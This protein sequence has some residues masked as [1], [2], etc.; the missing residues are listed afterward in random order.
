MAAAICVTWVW[1]LSLMAAPAPSLV[2]YGGMPAPGGGCFKAAYRRVFDSVQI[3]DRGEV[4]FRAAVMDGNQERHGI[5]CYSLADKELRLVARDDRFNAGPDWEA[6][7]VWWP[8]FDRR[9]NVLFTGGLRSTDS[10]RRRLFVIFQDD[11]HVQVPLLRS[12]D[13][14]ARRGSWVGHF[15]R[16]MTPEANSRGDTVLRSSLEYFEVLSDGSEEFRAEESGVYVRW[17]GNAQWKPVLHMFD[18]APGGG[19]VVGTFVDKGTPSLGD[20]QGV[21][22][23]D[24]GDVCYASRIGPAPEPDFIHDKRAVLYRPYGE[25]WQRI[26]TEGDELEYF[27][28]GIANHVVVSEIHVVGMNN[29]GHVACRVREAGPVAKD[30]LF[31]Y[32]NGQWNRVAGY[33][34]PA[35]VPSSRWDPSKPIVGEFTCYDSM[36][37]ALSNSR[38]PDGAPGRCFP[39]VVFQ[40]PVWPGQHYSPWFTTT[41]DIYAFGMG[42]KTLPV[43]PGP[44]RGGF[45]PGGEEVVDPGTPAP[46]PPGGTLDFQYARLGVN[47]DGFI[48]VHARTGGATRREIIVLTSLDQDGDGLLDVW[49]TEGLDVNG[50]GAIDLDLPALHANPRHKDLFLEIDYMADARHSDRPDPRAVQRVIDAFAQAPVENPDGTNGIT[51]H[52]DMTTADAIPP[53][54]FLRVPGQWA[55]LVTNWFGTA[56]ERAGAN[57]ADVLL[58]KR[59]VFRY[60]IFGHQYQFRAADGHWR[61]TTSSGLGELPGNDFLVTLGAFTPVADQVDLQAGTLMHE[62]GHTL[63]LR[64]GGD[65]DIN[66]KPNYLSV[67]SYSRQFS[68]MI[69]NRP[70]DY[71]RGLLPDLDERHLDERGGIGGSTNDLS[72]FFFDSNGDGYNDMLCLI[73][74]GAPVD[75]NQ[76]TNL[77]D[78]EVGADINSLV[79]DFDADGNPVWLDGWRGNEE[80]NRVILHDFND[81]THLHYNFRHSRNYGQGVNLT[82]SHAEMDWD[83]YQAL[84]RLAEE[85]YASAGGKLRIERA[86]SG[87]LRLTWPARAPACRLQSSASITGPW[88]NETGPFEQ[89][90]AHWQWTVLPAERARFYRLKVD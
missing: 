64:H 85:Y 31:V 23:S 55:E 24:Q 9:G 86:D 82:R 12:D 39:E 57:A 65:D 29:H 62:L 77:T 36:T 60:C 30:H 46:D 61:K 8:R 38:F 67:M 10:D 11:G 19:F 90:N 4:L 26:L 81:W 72:V 25:N 41:F 20:T 51:L 48:V 63:G 37:A 14:V 66:A 59:S 83:T 75:W 5:Y 78:T 70:L 88:V 22:I 74:G 34:D 21:W 2:A 56:A 76:N 43:L 54:P 44:I 33:G 80:T 7:E 87:L 47:A 27:H 52:V 84:Q 40:T 17:A 16:F 42:R 50:D 3:S 68:L 69:T 28:E 35:P 58:A 32:A 49:E 6:T 15:R 1:E 53:V 89:Q 79:Y 45:S 73:H 18:P 13:I 71:S